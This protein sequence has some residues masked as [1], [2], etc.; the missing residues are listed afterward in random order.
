MK[1]RTALRTISWNAST[2]TFSVWN[3]RREQAHRLGADRPT[4]GR[5]DESVHP[6]APTVRRQR[7]SVT[8]FANRRLDP[9]LTTF[10][11]LAEEMA[12]A[13]GY[14]AQLTLERQLAELVRLRVAQVTP[15]SYCL[16]LHTRV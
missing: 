14:T 2:G 7:M 10:H 5:I 3:E 13:F 12:R 11:G 9:A 8:E 4:Q 6:C 15:C 1:R 16:V